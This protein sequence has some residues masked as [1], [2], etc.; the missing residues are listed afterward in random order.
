MAT[1]VMYLFVP[2]QDVSK[3]SKLLKKLFVDIDCELGHVV[4][5]GVCVQNEG[6]H[7]AVRVP[8]SGLPVELDRVEFFENLSRDLEETS[9]FVSVFC[10]RSYQVSGLRQIRVEDKVLR[11]RAGV[12]P[13]AREF[14]ADNAG[15]VVSLGLF[16]VANE[17]TLREF[18]KTPIFYSTFLM[19]PNGTQNRLSYPNHFTS[20]MV[21]F[22]RS[23][24]PTL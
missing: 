5:Q 16:Q 17:V 7:G 9:L 12:L 3:A 10:K 23:T 2:L 14:F 15:L 24:F 13:L 11:V 21:F 22:F 18:F 19:L 4:W 6:L 20:A 8:Y 1:I